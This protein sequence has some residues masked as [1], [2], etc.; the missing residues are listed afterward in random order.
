MYNGVLNTSGKNKIVNKI[1][2]MGG[3]GY[4]GYTIWRIKEKRTAAKSI[5]TEAGNEHT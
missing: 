5:K 3:K 4:K 2:T 1:C